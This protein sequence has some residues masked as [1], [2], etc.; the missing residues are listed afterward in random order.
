MQV[1]YLLHERTGKLSKNILWSSTILSSTSNTF[2]LAIGFRQYVFYQSMN[3]LEEE[4]SL[5]NHNFVRTH[6]SY[7]VNA[8]QIEQFNS[9]RL[10]P[11]QSYR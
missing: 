6:Q 2:S 1:S 11:L 10:R 9:K 8:R 5:C 4:L 7:L 3:M